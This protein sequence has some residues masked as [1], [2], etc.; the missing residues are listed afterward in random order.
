MKALNNILRNTLP[1]F[2]TATI[3]AFSLSSCSH[4]Q[5]HENIEKLPVKAMSLKEE[6]SVNTTTPDKE[7]L[8]VHAVEY[9]AALMDEPD[10]IAS[11]NSEISILKSAAC[12]EI[13]NYEPVD[14]DTYFDMYEGKVWVYTKVEMP[15]GQKGKIQH[16]YY[17]GDK[18]IQT[19]E[20]DVKGPTFRTRSYK[21]MTEN[22]C[23]DWKVEILSE[24]GQLL[25]TVEFSVF[26]PG[27][28]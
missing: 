5:E 27:G 11:V 6:A 8:N 28:C 22:L 4:G 18:K 10:T 19:I 13:E 16:V 23:G 21:T 2:A 14:P 20:L 15:K 9:G 12:T 26:E 1:V 24:N 3:I 25:D 7:D 17:L